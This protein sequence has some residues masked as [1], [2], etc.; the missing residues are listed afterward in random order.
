M[1]RL[2]LSLLGTFEASLDEVPLTGFESNKVRAL[3]AYLAVESARPQRREVLGALLWPDR[4]QQQALY[5]LRNS[6]SD[7]RHLLGD[8]QAAIPLLLVTHDTVQFNPAS[9][10]WLDVA[11][12][13]E[14]S[15]SSGTQGLRDTGS[16]VNVEQF[17]RAVSLYQGGFLEG[18]TVDSLP[19]EEWALFTREQLHRQALG[20]MN[21]LAEHFLE[22]GE[23]ISAQRYAQLQ[24]GLEPWLEEAY[25]Q[26]MR[27]LALAG[28][29]SEAL[30]QFEICRRRLAEELSVEPAEETIRL[31]EQIR[32]GK[33]HPGRA[34]N[35]RFHNLPA[36]V[37]SFIGRE[38]E[39]GQVKDL[40]EKHRLA[41]LTGAGGVGKSRLSLRVAE[42]VLG[43]FPDGVWLAELAPL[44]DP[45]LVPQ[46]VARHLGLGVQAGAQVLSRLQDYLEGKSLLLV[47]DNCEHLVESCARLAEAL[48]AAC[49][50]LHLLVTS[51]E[52]LGIPGEIPFRVPSLSLPD[53]SIENQRD[54]KAGLDQPSPGEIL[55]QSEAVRL[56]VERAET[57]SP[58]FALTSANVPAITQV[59]VRLDGIP[60]A[61]ELAAAR[62]AMMQ[63]DEIAGR[64]DDCFALLT[65]GNRAALHR[66]QTLRASIDWSY[67]L[68]SPLEQGLLQRL[69]VFAGDCTLEA[70]E[71]V[72]CGEMI[73]SRNVLDLLTQLVNK[74][75]VNTRLQPGSATRYHMLETIRQYA[76]ER[77]AKAGQI[78]AARDKHLQY[79]LA[80]AEKAEGGLRGPEQPHLLDLLE[81]ELDNLRLALEYSLKVGEQPAWKLEAGLGIAGALLWFWHPRNR[82]LEGLQWLERLLALE[83]NTRGEQGLAPSRASLRA[84]ALYVA[85]WLSNNLGDYPKSARFTDEGVELYRSLG[86]PGRRGLAYTTFNSGLLQKIIGNLPEANRL[87][88]ESRAIFREEGDP[89]GTSE[90]LLML[91]IFAW[92]RLEYDKARKYHEEALAIKKAIGDQDGVA[93]ALF[94]LG[95]LEFDQGNDERARLLCE[96]SLAIFSAIHSEFAIELPLYILG[97]LEGIQGNHARAEELYQ[98]IVSIGQRQG[99]ESTISYGL[100]NQGLLALAQD[101][102]LGAEQKYAECLA[103][104]RKHNPGEFLR[105]SLWSLGT[106]AWVKGEFAQAAERFTEALDLSQEAGDRLN[107]GNA[108]FGLGRVAFAKND[109]PRAREYLLQALKT[110]HTFST[111]TWDFPYALEALALVEI[112]QDQMVGAVQLLAATQAFHQRFQKIR[113]SKERAM[114]L[115]AIEQVRG[116]LGEE[117]FATA[118]KEGEALGLKQAVMLVCQE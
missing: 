102:L 59:C 40:L 21:H 104:N 113:T 72:C 84:K 49:P 29:R 6:L 56:F 39:T 106:I 111:N 55:E 17:A 13:Q 105:S 36:Q 44:D 43:N 93:G 1:T 74:S 94:Y 37:T 42:E 16:Q 86:Q 97:I 91:G 66:Y 83:E 41:T 117:A 95:R 7:L 19:F 23:Y 63:V 89:F 8:R 25:R 80:L 48:L 10:H 20:L 107:E 14:L 11:E 9:D 33:I 101:D 58:G 52:T 79:Y 64:L 50:G 31:Y 67:M 69:S 116:A 18:F 26:W 70:A 99:N 118:W 112:A 15:G 92:D 60:L 22:C 68:L 85:G 98:E 45:E 75:L 24:V 54:G 73:E 35:P 115:S 3:L 90:S 114:R 30:A 110:C 71:F 47:L 12:F 76:S 61:I 28:Q 88:E 4:P 2:R 46:I 62:V 57:A 100:Y 78:E 5:Y 51:R 96:Q 32:N 82:H 34:Q 77:L 38:K 81:A 108:L 27:A 53:L 103:F 109:L 65:G 87:L